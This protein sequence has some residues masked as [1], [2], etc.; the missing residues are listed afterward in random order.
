[1]QKEEAEMESINVKEGDK[2]DVWVFWGERVFL[3][4]C[5]VLVLFQRWEL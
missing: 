2:E 4:V 3:G 5:Y 1:M